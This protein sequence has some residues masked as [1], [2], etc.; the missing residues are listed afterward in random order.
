VVRLDWPLALVALLLV[1]LACGVAL[2]AARRRGRYAIRY[3]NIDVL[4]TVAAPTARRRAYLPAVCAMF[5]ATCALAALARPEARV[6]VAREPAS[7]VLAVDMSGSMAAD[8]VEPTRLAA[9]QTA[10][11]RFVSGLP[12]QDRVGLVTFSD[13][14]SVAAPLTRDRAVVLDALRFAAAPGQGTAIGDAIARSVELLEPEPVGQSRKLESAAGASAVMPPPMAILLLSDGAQTR[15]RLTPLEG[16]ERATARHIPVYSIALGTP[17]G[18]ITAGVITLR[19]PPDPVTLRRIAR[20][21]GGTFA[22]P[23][24]AM[25]LDDA[26][27]R[28][29]SRLGSTREW[30]ELTFLL[31]GLAALFALAGGAFSAAWQERLP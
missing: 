14:S 23:E 4:A 18:V 2:V 29:A 21:T 19:V 27:A 26:Y 22:A 13:T 11:R 1:P 3:T 8:D 24:D 31:V 15:G 30:R 9:A 17:G 20:S 10:I 16:A 7:I 28:V 12:K 25:R 6:A 5:A